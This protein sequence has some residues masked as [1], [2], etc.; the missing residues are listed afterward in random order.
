MGYGE[1]AA[2][3]SEENYRLA[4]DYSGDFIQ[5]GKCSSGCLTHKRVPGC[6]KHW[7]QPCSSFTLLRCHHK[8]KTNKR[9]HT[10]MICQRVHVSCADTYIMR[11]RCTRSNSSFSAETSITWS[12]A[13]AVRVSG[14]FLM[15]ELE[16]FQEIMTYIPHARAQ[17]N[18]LD[19]LVLCFMA[20]KGQ[21]YFLNS[22]I[23]PIICARKGKYLA[24]ATE[25]LLICPSLPL[26][27]GNKLFLLSS[28]KLK[29]VHTEDIQ[30]AMQSIH[31]ECQSS[32]CFL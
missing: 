15:H 11:S 27:K 25:N 2:V 26:L 13:T 22:F 12:A 5:I 3:K 28:S 10:S 32:S 17:T 4:Q 30:D 31:S 6:S 8:G 24:N 18:A 16:H 19:N 20:N 14:G 1:L 29:T 23:C 21:I 7:V 9:C